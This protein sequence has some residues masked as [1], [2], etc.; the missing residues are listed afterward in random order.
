M[1]VELE[2]VVKD[3]CILGGGG[4]LYCMNCGNKYFVAQNILG[5]N[6]GQE[7]RPNKFWSKT[8]VAE[9]LLGSKQFEAKENSMTEKILAEKFME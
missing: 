5:P 4:W 2:V 1:W 3:K 8:W 6:F 7:F 9:I